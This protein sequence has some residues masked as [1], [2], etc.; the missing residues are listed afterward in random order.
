MAEL[1]QKAFKINE[2]RALTINAERIDWDLLTEGKAPLTTATQTHRRNHAW[3]QARHYRLSI[4][5]V[6]EPHVQI[7]GFWLAPEGDEAILA[8]IA[9]QAL[10]PVPEAIRTA[11]KAKAEVEVKDL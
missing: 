2:Q 6:G 1:I 7:N 3:G 11:D 4:A 8:E 9:E 5:G 10:A